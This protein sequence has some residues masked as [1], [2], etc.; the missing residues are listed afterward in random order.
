MNR[1]GYSC[2]TYTR[3]ECDGC[4]TILPTRE[5]TAML[6]Y[7]ISRTRTRKKMPAAAATTTSDAKNS[8]C[9]L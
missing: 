9:L 1:P 7:G 8:T 3:T 6:K 4:T 5:E 2:L